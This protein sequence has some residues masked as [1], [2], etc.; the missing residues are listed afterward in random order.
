MGGIGARGRYGRVRIEGESRI[1]HLI[2]K[3]ISLSMT[4]T[5]EAVEKDLYAKRIMFE[6]M[7]LGALDALARGDELRARL[8]LQALAS[9]N[10]EF[11]PYER[12]FHVEAF[13]PS[14]DP[15]GD[16]KRGF[17]KMHPNFDYLKADL[18]WQEVKGEYANR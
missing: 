15:I 2:E 4:S 11:D 12:G 17:R 3:N 10:P 13:I 8:H 1:N 14:N 5:F 6:T 7:Y 9:R 18:L 16:D